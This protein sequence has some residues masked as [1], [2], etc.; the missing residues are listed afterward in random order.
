MR[1]EEMKKKYLETL[2]RIENGG[3]VWALDHA[4]II[5]E[6]QKEH[7]EW[8]TIVDDM[9][10]LE[11]ITGETYDD[12]VPYFGAILT[13]EGKGALHT[14]KTY[15]AIPDDPPG[16]REFAYL[17]YSSLSP[18]V[19]CELYAH[20]LHRIC[21]VFLDYE[22]LPERFRAAAQGMKHEGKT[23]DSVQAKPEIC[24]GCE[25]NIRNDGICDPL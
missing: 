19:W 8:L 20:P 18:S 22:H 5:R 1:M 21:P 25:K 6:L 15:T 16:L 24:F 14:L 17:W 13:A 9:K 10:E 3:T 12:K 2:E 7:P 11:R 4:Q 23:G